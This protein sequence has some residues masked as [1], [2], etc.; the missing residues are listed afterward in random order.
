MFL[1]SAE[2]VTEQQYSG[3]NDDFISI[4]EFYV[5]TDDFLQFMDIVDNVGKPVYKWTKGTLPGGAFVEG[6]LGAITQY[7]S[8]RNNTNIARPFSEMF[9]RALLVGI[10]DAVTGELANM[11]AIPLALEA[12]AACT[13]A[14]LICGGVVYI[15]V[16][17]G[18]TLFMDYFVWAPINNEFGISR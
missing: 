14:A 9:S 1:R 17:N 12:G 2:N 6:A 10:E 8:D 4:L 16:A 15:A 5:S 7:A 3:N 11:A 18:V 13:V